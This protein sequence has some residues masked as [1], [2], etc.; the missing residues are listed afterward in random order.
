MDWEVGPAGP[1]RLQ[2]RTIERL[3]REET[4]RL[5][6][7]HSSTGCSHPARGW[8]ARLR[9][10]D[11][12]GSRAAYRKSVV[13]DAP[14]STASRANEQQV[15]ALYR[16]YVIDATRRR[17][18]D[19]A[20]GLGHAHNGCSTGRRKCSAG[21]LI[22]RG[23]DLHLVKQSLM[24]PR[25]CCSRV[26]ARQVGCPRRPSGRIA[27]VFSAPRATWPLPRWG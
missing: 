21:R 5:R 2:D 4:G 10:P 19:S 25:R 27:G 6:S 8:C 9:K 14:R 17:A 12:R 24:R 15:A 1:Q 18:T 3:S 23:A 22:W 26:H 20:N 11:R 16:H 7:G 13:N